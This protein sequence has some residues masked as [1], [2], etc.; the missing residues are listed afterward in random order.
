MSAPVLITGVGK[1]AGFSLA[2]QLLLN[3]TP[4]IGTYRADYP[5]LERLRELGAELYAVDLYS[6]D[7]RSRLVQQVGDRHTRLRALIHNASDWLPDDH[8]DGISQV[9]QRMMAIHVEVPLC[10]NRAL[11][12]LLQGMAPE[13]ADIIHITDYVAETGSRKHMAYAASKAALENLT[14]S[15]AIHLAPS[16][17]VN[18][19]APALLRFNPGDSESYRH[20]ALSKALIPREGG[21]EELLA[22][23][24]YLLNSRYI[25][26][27]TLHIDGGRHLRRG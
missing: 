24:D 13:Q 17:K 20:R 16:I 2:E 25:T 3:D 11:T 4:V 10:L 1:R 14:R 8:P 23:V 9:L 19:I 5:Q 22:S 27:R 7:Q 18:A 12:P 26:G 6:A 15:F 21:F